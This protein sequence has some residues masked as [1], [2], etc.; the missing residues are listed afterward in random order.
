MAVGTNGKRPAKRARTGAGAG[1]MESF[2]GPTTAGV[3][4]AP[5]PFAQPQRVQANQSS[6]LDPADFLLSDDRTNPTKAFV[7]DPDYAAVDTILQQANQPQTQTAAVMHAS[8]TPTAANATTTPTNTTT[9]TT[10]APTA[11]GTR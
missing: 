6:H 2:F 8:T 7:S 3:A 5:S 4:P 9:T 1:T 11:T 10:T